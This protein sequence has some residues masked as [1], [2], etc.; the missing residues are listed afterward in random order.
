MFV[1]NQTIINVLDLCLF[2]FQIEPPSEG[3]LVFDSIRV[4]ALLVLAISAPLSHKSNCNIP[5]TMFSYA[6]TFLGRIS[7]AL[8]DIMSQNS[9][10][11]YLT[12]CSR[13]TGFSAIEFREDQPCLYLSE[14]NLPHNSTNDTSGSFATI[15]QEK[16]DGNSDIQSSISEGSSKVATS[17]VKYQLEV[18]DEVV[19]SMNAILAK[20]KDI[21]RLVQSGYIYE[22]LKNLRLSIRN[23]NCLHVCLY[24]HF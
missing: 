6:V 1:S 22:V 5:P 3:K 13:S 20:V 17:L 9:L 19:E 10:L 24:F 21:W 2:L 14:G 12:Q 8:R 18:H 7:Y 15:L 23:F 11:D 16:R 4:V